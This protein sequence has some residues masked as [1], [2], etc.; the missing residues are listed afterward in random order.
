ML[1]MPIASNDGVRGVGVSLGGLP[2]WCQQLLHLPEGAVGVPG[3]GERVDPL[4]TR[5]DRPHHRLPPRRRPPGVVWPRPSAQ[6]V[7]LLT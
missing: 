4:M 7:D 1:C 3:R 5:I 6:L 2:P